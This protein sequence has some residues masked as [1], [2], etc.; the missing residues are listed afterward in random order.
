MRSATGPGACQLLVDIAISAS[1]TANFYRSLT[2]PP[3]HA[4]V[5]LCRLLLSED[6]PTLLSTDWSTWIDEEKDGVRWN[7]L[8]DRPWEWWKH[9][10]EE[11]DEEDEHA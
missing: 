6:R 4:H 9:E 3:A 5:V 2:L 1:R 10:G 8:A 11:E 7:D